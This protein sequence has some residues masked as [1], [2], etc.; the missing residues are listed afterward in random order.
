MVYADT[1]FMQ[2]VHEG[3]YDFTRF[4]DSGHRYLF[5]DFERID[6]GLVAGAGTA[7]LWSI[8]YF[9]RALTRSPRFGELVGLCFFWL[10][11]LDPIL[12][13]RYSLDAASSVFFVGR[14]A[15]APISP[16]EAVDYYRGGHR[17]A[18]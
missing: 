4:T 11:H 18:D 12:D 2:Q 5:R 10:E 13:Y 16:P 14:K 3:A 6:S 17:H 15:A 7:L 9:V 1:P 8:R